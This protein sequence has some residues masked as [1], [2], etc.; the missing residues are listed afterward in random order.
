MAAK[1]SKKKDRARAPKQRWSVV[2][3]QGFG[4]SVPDD[5]N[6]L[7]IS[8]QRDNG[9]LRLGDLYETRLEIRWQSPNWR[10]T[11]RRVWKRYLKQM[12]IPVRKLDEHMDD[13]P[14]L[15]GRMKREGWRDPIVMRT[16]AE[17]PCSFHL[18]AQGVFSRRFILARVYG[19]GPADEKTLVRPIVSRLREID[20]DGDQPWSIYGF[21]CGVPSWAALHRA[22]LRPGHLR[23]EFQGS[24]GRLRW[25]RLAMAGRLLGDADLDGWLAERAAGDLKR[26][27][28]RAARG[29]P[30]DGLGLRFP[31]GLIRRSSSLVA[32]W[33]EEDRD[34]LVVLTARGRIADNDDKMQRLLGSWDLSAE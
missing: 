22:Q 12:R 4:L 13:V 10:D 20:P 31:G 9:M 29:L 11:S 6:P 32:A 30:R 16:H 17:R 2:N 5:W 26:S 28:G 14:G 3:W 8:G 34:Q 24:G 15:V 23:L 7:E 18:V 25:E 21:S 19:D 33:H 27:D 1:T